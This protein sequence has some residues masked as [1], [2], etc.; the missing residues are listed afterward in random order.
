M[1]GIRFVFAAAAAVLPLLNVVKTLRPVSVP[2]GPQT[3]QAF[4]DELWE[5]VFAQTDAVGRPF[6]DIRCFMDSVLGPGLPPEEFAASPSAVR[7][8]TPPGFELSPR[9]Y[10]AG[11]V[12]LNLTLTS[13][14]SSTGLVAPTIRPV[15]PVHPLAILPTI[16]SPPPSVAYVILGYFLLGGIMTGIFV[17]VVVLLALRWAV[18]PASSTITRTPATR[19]S[20]RPSGIPRWVPRVTSSFN[21]VGE[22]SSS[23]IC[24][25]P[26]EVVGK[27]AQCMGEPI[28][29]GPVVNALKV[30]EIPQQSTEDVEQVQEA[31]PTN[32]TVSVDAPS[33]QVF[34]PTPPY[35]HARSPEL[36]LTAPILSERVRSDTAPGA[37]LYQTPAVSN[38]PASSKSPASPI[39]GSVIYETPTATCQ[40]SSA[41]SLIIYETPRAVRI[42]SIYE[43]GSVTATP[44]YGLQTHR[45]AFPPTISYYDASHQSCMGSNGRPNF[46]PTSGYY[47]AG[48][49]PAPWSRQIS[50]VPAGGNKAHR[51]W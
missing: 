50:Q 14:P 49:T 5:E 37:I 24:D 42:P 11:R 18:T 2:F 34:E 25:T 10:L 29:E 31:K 21:V 41:P 12:A 40:V 43:T 8:P 26:P 22:F 39:P 3:Y 16:I 1:P 23:S 27:P 9:P 47:Y 48:Y 6:H 20:I 32:S 45:T 4:K 46:L 38:A 44:S 13:A 33:Q 35:S 51:A 15:A 28:N 36:A 30:H 19:A 17:L 7:A